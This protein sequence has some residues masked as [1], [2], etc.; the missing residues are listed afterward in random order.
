MDRAGR[1]F[2]LLLSSLGMAVTCGVMG[3]VYKVD[4]SEGLLRSA[5]GL[6]GFCILVHSTV[7]NHVNNS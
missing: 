2:F 5:V 4:A 7:A 6:R 1:R 3:V